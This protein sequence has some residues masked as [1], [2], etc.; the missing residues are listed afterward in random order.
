MRH[1]Q[2]KISLEQFKSRM[3]GLISAFD[4]EA[5]N[6]VDFTN[7]QILNHYQLGN[8]TLFPSDIVIPPEFEVTD[9]TDYNV[10]AD[11]VNISGK[12]VF[13]GDTEIK[14]LTY[15][16]VKKWYHFFVEYFKLLKSNKCG[17]AYQSA[18]DYFNRENPFGVGNTANYYAELDRLFNARGGRDFYQ[19]L[20]DICFPTFIITNPEIANYWGTTT[21]PYVTAL[22]WSNWFVKWDKFSEITDPAE[23]EN[24][25]DCCVCVEYVKRGGKAFAEE[26]KLW[27]E[28]I[29]QLHEDNKQYFLNTGCFTLPISFLVNI[30]DLGQMDIFSKEWEAND[31]Y[32]CECVWSGGTVMY[33]PVLIDNE[34]NKTVVD[35]SF[36]LT[37]NTTGSEY[38]ETYLENQFQSSAWT[39]SLTYHIRK[40]K[41]N[42]TSDITG[43]A[44]NHNGVLVYNPSLENMAIK[45]NLNEYDFGV[46]AYKNQALPIFENDYVVYDGPIKILQG[47]HYLVKYTNS[48]PYVIVNNKRIIATKDDSGQYKFYFNSVFCSPSPE[49]GK[50]IRLK[51]KFVFINNIPVLI[52]NDDYVVYDNIQYP[53]FEHDVTIDGE[54][55]FTKNRGLYTHMGVDY[56]ER[57]DVYQV[58]SN[59]EWVWYDVCDDINPHYVLITYKYIVY[60]AN[61]LTGYTESYL[62]S[63]RIAETSTD[64]IGNVLPG[65]F[66][67]IYS[68]DSEYYHTSQPKEGEL[69]DLF[70]QVGE[71]R[72]KSLIQNVSNNTATV[73]GDVITNMTFYYSNL[74]TQEPIEDTIV[75]ID[76]NDEKLL[77]NIEAIRQCQNKKQ[78]YIGTEP[79]SELM[80]C[81]FTYYIKA[82]LAFDSDKKIYKLAQNDN[83]LLKYKETVHLKERNGLYYLNDDD[84]YVIRYMEI[85]PIPCHSIYNDWDNK[86]VI[87]NYAYFEKIVQIWPTSEFVDTISA[88]LGKQFM[89]LPV[90]RHEYKLGL[91]L[92][93]NIESDIYIDRGVNAAIERHIKLGE[94]S[95]MEALENYGNNS[96][97]MIGNKI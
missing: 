73:V 81:D 29:A 30:D 44:Y 42:Y 34:G 11:G 35:N 79:I 6:Y 67:P 15:P 45:Y 93:Q 49:D 78:N 51:G 25:E 85:I 53:W 69:L 89:A 55:Y 36:I 3:P 84:Y 50:E 66:H 65:W 20:T 59:E 39:D 1:I 63:L 87:S 27:L 24:E 80:S 12:T 5:K 96:F 97:L 22:K 82:N 61:I 16:T 77:D 47:K 7:D 71:A 83:V 48:I 26:L 75:S 40:N 56:N 92:P 70:Y 17:V 2:Y 23:C 88:E 57:I 31:N 68:E 64:D 54:R 4:N 91:S 14:V 46:I 74:S 37:T 13:S 10:C 41:E 76:V 9:Y 62:D 8:Y 58:P 33:Q 18:L 52:E 19:W 28:T 21:L 60:K 95:T 94:V 38:D 90:F 32:G 86:D 72:N 43:Y